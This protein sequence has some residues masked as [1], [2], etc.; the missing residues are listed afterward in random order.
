MF[1]KKCKKEVKLETDSINDICKDMYMLDFA[2]MLALSNRR[3]NKIKNK[4][5]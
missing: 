3:R 5:K 1:W 4:N 2:I